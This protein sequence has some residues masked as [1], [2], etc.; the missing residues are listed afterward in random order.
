MWIHNQKWSISQIK[1]KDLSFFF[2]LKIL[3]KAYTKNREEIHQKKRKK[4]TKLTAK[5]RK[6][7]NWK[8]NEKLKEQTN[9]IPRN[10][11]RKDFD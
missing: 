6:L 5:D 10:N 2:L 9:E 7:R 8:K 4:T 11:R 1:Q 3:D